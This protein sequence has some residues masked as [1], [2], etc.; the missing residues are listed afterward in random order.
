MDTVTIT[1][2][3]VAAQ[4]WTGQDPT[5]KET[6]R[7]QR[8]EQR[9]RWACSEPE[10]KEIKKT[11]YKLEINILNTQYFAGVSPAEIDDG[12]WGHE[13]WVS[14]KLRLQRFVGFF[15]NNRKID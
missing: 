1:G 14:E 7:L 15:P 10:K 11:I 8:N 9:S 12:A 2:V 3:S 5:T 4:D 13:P 6:N